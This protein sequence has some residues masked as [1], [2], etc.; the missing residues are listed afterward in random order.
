M[1][2]PLFQPK[3]NYHANENFFYNPKITTTHIA[4][5][6]SVKTGK[7]STRT[8]ES[9]PKRGEIFKTLKKSTLTLGK[10]GGVV[11]LR[12]APYLVVN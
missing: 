11:K 3:G 4:N 12:N 9:G 6:Y 8:P 5:Q 10:G 2:H 1:Q 7:H